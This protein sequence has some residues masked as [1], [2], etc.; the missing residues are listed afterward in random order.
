MRKHICVCPL[1]LPFTTE[2]MSLLLSEDRS[3]V[4]A[5]KPW[6]LRKLRPSMVP[7]PALTPLLAKELLVG[8]FTRARADSILTNTTKQES[9]THFLTPLSPFP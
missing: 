2:E 3:L 6:H 7:S 5:Q 4:R 1:S 9:S 8:T